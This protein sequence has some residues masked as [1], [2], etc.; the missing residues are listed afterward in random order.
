MRVKIPIG[1]IGIVL[2]RGAITNRV[3]PAGVHYLTPFFESVIVISTKEKTYEVMEES[4]V[5]KTDADYVDHPL[6]AKTA[7]GVQAFILYTLRFFVD[8]TNARRVMERFGSLEEAVRMV[9][10]AESRQVVRQTLSERRFNAS[11]LIGQPLDEVQKP[12]ES[13]LRERLA[14]NGL[15]LSFF[16]LRAIDLGEYGHLTEQRRNAQEK[17]EK[18]KADTNVIMEQNRR[19]ELISQ[20]EAKRVADRVTSDAQAAADADRIKQVGAKRTQLEVAKANAEM[21]KINVEAEAD[22]QRLRADAESKVKQIQAQ[23]ETQIAILRAESDA[24]VR[25][26]LADAD[27]HGY[28]A[29]AKV[30]TPELVTWQ[31]AQTH[32]VFAQRWDGKIPMFSDP[33]NVIPFLD[34]TDLVASQKEEDKKV[35]KKSK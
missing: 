31:R 10:K 32:L 18:E 15:T 22:T 35:A 1:S 23:T 3:L 7:D 27:A 24:K 8:H 26:A 16:G 4:L 13:V 25:Q 20:S 19:A 17:L 6:D 29:L 12:M 28:Q 33:K 21:M 34:L 9:V 11:D 30:L 5:G 14:A 2:R